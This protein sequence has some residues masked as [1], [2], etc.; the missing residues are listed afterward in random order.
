MSMTTE[1][2]LPPGSAFRMGAGLVVCAG[3]MFASQDAIAKHLTAD[4]SPFQ[5]AW[6]RFALHAVLVGIWLHLRGHHRYLRTSRLPLQLARATALLAVS[7]SMYWAVSLI[8]LAQATVIQFLSPIIVTLL[9]VAFLGERIGWRRVLAI[10]AGFFGVVVV[11]APEIGALSY[12]MLLPLI[13]AFC[14]AIFVLL[15][16][17]LS[18]PAEALPAFGLMPLICAVLLLPSLPFVWS[19]IS[20]ENMPLFLLM[21]LCGTAA[22]IF[23]QYGLQIASASTMAPFLYAQVIW[24]AG[25]S[26]LIFEDILTISFFFGAAVIISSGVAIWWLEHHARRRPSSPQGVPPA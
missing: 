21:G 26:I 3:C 22:H 15:T 23:L 25:L 14:L 5:V 1:M 7:L 16:R 19:A 10:S 2:T 8:P 4:H 11:M 18:D 17:Q 9:S 6:L 12:A 20:I 13:T 24:A